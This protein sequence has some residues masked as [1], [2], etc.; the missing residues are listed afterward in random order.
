MPQVVAPF[1]DSWAIRLMKK[2]ITTEETTT[3]SKMAIRALDSGE[4][5]LAFIAIELYQEYYEINHKSGFNDLQCSYVINYR[6]HSNPKRSLDEI[7]Q[8]GMDYV[9]I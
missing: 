5:F 6:V 4:Y 2:K 7:P 9:I 3:L 1:V 8:K